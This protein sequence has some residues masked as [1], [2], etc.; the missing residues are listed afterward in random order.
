MS[1]N[2]DSQPQKIFDLGERTAIFGERVIRFAKTIQR[3]EISRPLILQLVRS[4]TSVG[5]NY[6]EADDAGSRN[7]FFHRI[8][9]CQ[10]ESREVMHWFRMLVAAE[11][12][13]REEARALWAEA[14]EL[15]H[16]FAAIQPKKST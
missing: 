2:G 4:G 5:A 1:S 7:E 8:S 6:A 12:D 11:P 9:I 3:N 14:K 16:I 10:R 15:N 13:S